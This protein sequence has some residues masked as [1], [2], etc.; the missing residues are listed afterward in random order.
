MYAG[1]LGTILIRAPGDIFFTGNILNPLI[2]C[3]REAKNHAGILQL[4]DIERVRNSTLIL[5]DVKKV[6]ELVLVQRKTGKLEISC[7]DQIKSQHGEET[8]RIL[9]REHI[10][11]HVG[12]VWVS[13]WWYGEF[14]GGGMISS[15]VCW[16][17]ED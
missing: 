7:V 3:H 16:V 17:P 1:Y 15:S 12:K 5:A 2:G 13:R 8:P 10:E 14:F 6:P 4:A 11:D 9:S